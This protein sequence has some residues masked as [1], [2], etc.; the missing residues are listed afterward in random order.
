MMCSAG[1]AQLGERVAAASEAAAQRGQGP[2]HS[3]A[4]SE[5]D[6]S[7]DSLVIRKQLL[8]AGILGC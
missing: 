2:R 7:S 8:T 4:G 6:Y 1:V 3:Q 5:G